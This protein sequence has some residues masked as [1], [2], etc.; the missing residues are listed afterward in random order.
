MTE[1]EKRCQEEKASLEEKQTFTNPG[2]HD[3]EASVGPSDGQQVQPTKRLQKQH[4]CDTCLKH[5]RWKTNLK[6]HQRIHTGEKCYLCDQCGKT[7]NQ[8]S[9]LN[10]HQRIHTGEKP[11]RCDQCEKTFKYSSGLMYHKQIHTG[12]KHYFCDQCGKSFITKG[13]FNSHMRIHTGL[14]DVI[15]VRGDSNNPHI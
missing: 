6:I 9:S 12:E 14:I 7:F 1:M 3:D 11:Y 5:F 8:K 15:S 13:S 2:E 4:R 10:S